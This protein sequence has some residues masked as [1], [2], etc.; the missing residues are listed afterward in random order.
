M[1][2]AQAALDAAQLNLERTKVFAP[3]DGYVTNLNVYRGDYATAGT[4]KLALVDSHSFW[5]YGYFEETKLPHVRIGDKA[6]M[7][8]MSGG[9]LKGHV[10]EHLAGDL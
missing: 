2:Q 10:R 6:E 3:V 7:R 9:V 8:L 4:P 1:Q 5:V